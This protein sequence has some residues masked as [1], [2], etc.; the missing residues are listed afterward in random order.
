MGDRHLWMALRQ[1]KASAREPTIAG[2]VVLSYLKEISAQL[3]IPA[4]DSG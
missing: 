3:P 4:A 2:R 1:A